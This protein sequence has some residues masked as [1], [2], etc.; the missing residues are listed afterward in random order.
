MKSNKVKQILSEYACLVFLLVSVVIASI[1]SDQFL[2]LTNMQNLLKQGAVLCVLSMGLGLVLMSGC[3]D[4]SV[5]ANMAIASCITINLFDVIG[6]IPSFIVAVV[7]CVAVSCIN[8]LIIHLS[9]ARAMEIMMITFGMKLVYRGIAQALTGNVVYR[10][11]G[12]GLFASIGKGMIFGCIPTIGVIVIILVIILGVIL[13]KLRFGREVV[14]VGSNPEA[15]RLAGI[16]VNKTRL[17]CF[18]VAGVFCAIAGMLLASRTGAVKALSGDN[19]E[20][21][22]VCALSIGGFSMMGGFGSAWRCFVGAYVFTIINNILNLVGAD[23]YTQV[24]VQGCVMILAVWVDM[25]LR[26]KNRGGNI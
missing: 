15:A 16:S 1:I 12:Q 5:G 22:A 20:M 21:D 18:I 24:V 7:V 10:Y 8:M 26:V 19:W 2:S 11:V 9:K 6:V 4:L 13:D 23:A 3:I 14:Y 25:E 17:I